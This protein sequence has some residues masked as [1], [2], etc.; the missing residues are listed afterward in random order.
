M[1]KGTGPPW[2]HVS[3]PARHNV[4]QVARTGVISAVP[5]ASI[6]QS[7]SRHQFK[8]SFHTEFDTHLE[9]PPMEAL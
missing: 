4:L 6:P 8:I 2:L 1:R 9:L 5:S 3:G 7:A